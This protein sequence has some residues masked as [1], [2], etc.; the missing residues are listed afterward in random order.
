LKPG[1]LARLCAV[2][3]QSTLDFGINAIQQSSCDAVRGFKENLTSLYH[4]VTLKVPSPLR[5]H[6]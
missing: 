2:L 1:A 4:W 6:R 3:I 5:R